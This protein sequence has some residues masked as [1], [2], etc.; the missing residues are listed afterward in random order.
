MREITINEIVLNPSVAT[1]PQHIIVTGDFTTDFHSSYWLLPDG[2]KSPYY[3]YNFTSTLA[4]YGTELIPA[5]TFKIVDNSDFDGVYTVY[6]QASEDTTMYGATEYD[7]VTNTT[8]IYVSTLLPQRS[9]ITNGKIINVS[10]YKMVVAGGQPVVIDERQ[11]TTIGGINVVGKFS[12]SYGEITQQNFVKLAQNFAGP[13]APTSPLLGQAWFDT[14]TNVLKI[15][16][17][18]TWV[19]I[20]QTVLSFRH[21]QTNAAS[22]WTVQHNMNLPSP[23]I[24]D[25]TVFVNTSGGVKQILPND[26]TF[27][28]KDSI[29]IT[30]TTAYSGIAVI[31]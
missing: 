28:S 30:F 22:T 27:T 4:P 17:S 26:I 23:F 8:K 15:W 13:V 5:T 24:A 14:T 11:T 2:T 29:T 9:N 21:T 18:T 3:T 16:S 20:T 25:V 19:S 31:R 7:S 1:E 10:T 6:T 12:E